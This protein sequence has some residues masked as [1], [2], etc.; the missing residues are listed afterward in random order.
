MPVRSSQASTDEMP[1][2]L[3]FYSVSLLRNFTVS[4]LPF[5]GTGGVI[6]ALA[7]LVAIAIAD[8]E[9]VDA[10]I[11]GGSIGESVG[12]EPTTGTQSHAAMSGAG[13]KEEEPESESKL[14]ADGP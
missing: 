13:A 8:Y 9:Q 3:F 12:L 6:W 11:S 10:G 4:R 14:A 1:L 7:I 2:L 5:S